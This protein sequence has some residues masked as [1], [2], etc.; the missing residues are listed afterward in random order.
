MSLVKSLAWRYATKKYDTFKQ[1]SENQFQD[2]LS[3]VQLAV[4]TDLN[5][6]AGQFDV[7]TDGIERLTGMPPQSLKELLRSNL[8]RFI[9]IL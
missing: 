1:L 4:M 7:V 8:S 2:L 3:S 6:A 5:T 9:T